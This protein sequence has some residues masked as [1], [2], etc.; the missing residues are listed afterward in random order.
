MHVFYSVFVQMY[1]RL[2]KNL[3]V[4]TFQLNSLIFLKVQYGWVLRKNYKSKQIK[5]RSQIK[6]PIMQSLIY[7]LVVETTHKVSDWGWGGG[8]KMLIF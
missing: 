1:R 5:I 2:H 3:H 4:Y 8:V 7:S 6:D